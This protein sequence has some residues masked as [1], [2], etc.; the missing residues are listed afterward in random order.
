MV[1]LFNELKIYSFLLILL[2]KT[3][4][5]EFNKDDDSIVILN[6]LFSIILL[7]FSSLIFSFKFSCNE[8]EELSS[9]ILSKKFFLL[10]L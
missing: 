1:L 8:D 9:F 4:F 2:P 7:L 6:L 3:F 10:S 5:I